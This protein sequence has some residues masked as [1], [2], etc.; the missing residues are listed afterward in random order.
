VS[1]L[2]EQVERGAD[3]L[4]QASVELDRWTRLWVGNKGELLV[5]HL[6][7]MLYDFKY[8]EVHL[9]ECLDSQDRASVMERLT[10]HS[11]K[12]L[13]SMVRHWQGHMEALRE[14]AAICRA[15]HAER[16]GVRSAP[17]WHEES[18]SLADAEGVAMAGIDALGVALRAFTTRL[19]EETIVDSEVARGMLDFAADLRTLHE[20]LLRILP[21]RRFETLVP[22]LLAYCD[23]VDTMLIGWE[24]YVT[25]LRTWLDNDGPGPSTGEDIP[26]R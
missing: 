23:E 10:E 18:S 8:V 2:A 3:L 25:R 26:R 6:V 7:E 16:Q 5:W 21:L 12:V 19:V 22:A 20:R 9:S 24:G 17:E 11:D 4:I 13:W 14:R 15:A 1:S